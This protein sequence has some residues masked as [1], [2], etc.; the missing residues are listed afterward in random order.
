M[1]GTYEL[2]DA[3]FFHHSQLIDSIYTQCASYIGLAIITK[4][5]LLA[6]VQCLQILCYV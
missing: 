4:Q 1:A 5:E 6:T 2:G 3:D